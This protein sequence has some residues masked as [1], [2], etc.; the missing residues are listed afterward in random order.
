[1]RA[2]QKIAHDAGGRA[3]IDEI[4]DDEHA[5]LARQNFRGDAFQYGDVALRL[6]AIAR[7]RDRLDHSDAELARDDRRRHE[8]APRDGDDHL[9][10]PGARQPP[11]ERA[12]VAVKLVPGDGEV[13]LA[14]GARRRFAESRVHALFRSRDSRSTN[15]RVS[16]IAA[17]SAASCFERSTIEL[18]N[19]P[20]TK[21]GYEPIETPLW[22]SAMSVRSAA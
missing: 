5:R 9:E 7:N 1:M 8:A 14:Q 12:G 13:L 20:S 6:V 3:G 17:A 21:A 18:R 2:R 19:R 15:A 16:A 22:R 11:G 10:G 4:V